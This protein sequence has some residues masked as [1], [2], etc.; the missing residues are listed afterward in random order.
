MTNEADSSIIDSV[1]KEINVA[2]KKITTDSTSTE[3]NEV[4]EEVVKLPIELTHVTVGIAYVRELGEWAVIKIRH[5]P[6]TGDVGKLEITPSGPTKDFAQEK[7]KIEMA[8][9]FL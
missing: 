1:V 4:I 2:K 7:M 5:N 6:S 8:H 3:S 9:E